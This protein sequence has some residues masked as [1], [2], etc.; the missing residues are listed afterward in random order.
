M[1]DNCT[2]FLGSLLLKKDD[3]IPQ[4]MNSTN[5]RDAKRKHHSL[6]KI[7][8]FCSSMKHTSNVSFAEMSNYSEIEEEKTNN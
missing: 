2:L 1:L 4:K 5:N 8:N 3:K 7:H 6:V